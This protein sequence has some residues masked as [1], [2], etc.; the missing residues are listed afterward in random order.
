MCYDSNFVTMTH[1]EQL[2]A[3]NNKGWQLVR[4]EWTTVAVGTGW[5]GGLNIAVDSNN[6]RETETG[7]GD[8][9]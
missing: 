3:V 5:R 9:Y 6:L 4:R 1:R 2:I 8:I 7:Q